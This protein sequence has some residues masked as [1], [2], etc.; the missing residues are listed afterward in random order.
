[1]VSERERIR[2]ATATQTTPESLWLFDQTVVIYK[3]L[4]AS[5]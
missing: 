3:R 1:V 4:I 2:R 5:K